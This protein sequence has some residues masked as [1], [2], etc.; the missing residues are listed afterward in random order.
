M[1]T[2]ARGAKSK[3]GQVHPSFSASGYKKGGTNGTI[4]QHKINVTV[5]RHTRKP[6]R[7]LSA[8]KCYNTVHAYHGARR[9]RYPNGVECEIPLT[10]NI[11]KLWEE[12]EQV[13]RSPMYNS[14][15]S[16]RMA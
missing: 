1:I 8:S 3:S 10:R 15:T 9:N 13:A 4:I 12:N 14:P 16:C 6:R 11:Y 5:M 2:G 7:N